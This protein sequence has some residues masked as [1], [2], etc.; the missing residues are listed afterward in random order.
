MAKVVKAQFFLVTLLLLALS[1]FV[2][3]SFFRTTDI[4]SVTL[5]TT[6]EYTD[7]KN[8]HNAIIKKNT[9]MAENDWWNASWPYRKTM[10]AVGAGAP[11]EILITFPE[12]HMSYCNET[13]IINDSDTSTY[14]IYNTSGTPPTCSY[15]FNANVVDTFKVYYGNGT[16]RKPTLNNLKTGVAG[17]A[18][19]MGREETSNLCEHFEYVY[20]KQGV[21]LEC[22]IENTFANNQKGNYSINFTSLDL[23]FRGYIG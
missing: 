14:V 19:I 23:E 12:E 8:I 16:D 20:S 7:F 18:F 3:F 1:M 9:W 22:D 10:T 17:I 13:R 21:D 5:F 4:S 11:V 6:S 15:Y 2:L